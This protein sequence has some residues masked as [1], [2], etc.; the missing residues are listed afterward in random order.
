LIVRAGE[1]E[2]LRIDALHDAIEA[3]VPGVQLELGIV[4][5]NDELALPVALGEGAR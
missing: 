1:R 3:A 4:R 2:T 5:G